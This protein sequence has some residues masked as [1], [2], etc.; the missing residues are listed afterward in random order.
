MSVSLTEK[1]HRILF[2]I[3]VTPRSARD[4]ITGEREGAL[5]V[6]VRAAPTDGRAN[7]ACLQLLATA[8]GVRPSAV[9]LQHG[10]AGRVKRLAVEGLALAEVR[11]RLSR[12]LG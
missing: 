2:T 11:D 7:E 8:L 9:T 12:H 6:R 10:A 4:E 1:D 3:R 5:Q